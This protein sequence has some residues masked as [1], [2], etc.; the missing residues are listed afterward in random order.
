MFSAPV[1]HFVHSVGSKQWN[2]LFFVNTKCHFIIFDALN[3]VYCNLL[4]FQSQSKLDQPQHSNCWKVTAENINY[5]GKLMQFAGKLQVL[6]STLM[7]L[8]H[9]PNYGCQEGESDQTDHKKKTFVIVGG[10]W[11]QCPRHWSGFQSN[12]PFIEW[13]W[14]MHGKIDSSIP[15]R[16]HIPTGQS[17]FGD[18]EIPGREFPF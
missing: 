12:P 1:Q 11:R 10:T 14:F 17:C 7:L 16:I 13:C 4:T 18:T 6:T 9:P 2:I 5:V 8:P 3:M 15:K